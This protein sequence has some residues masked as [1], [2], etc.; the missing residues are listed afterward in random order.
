MIRPIYELKCRRLDAEGNTKE[1]IWRVT[2]LWFW[3]NPI[4][5]V[6]KKMEEMGSRIVLDSLRK[7]R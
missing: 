6:N 7:V 3:Q 2:M 1:Y 5:W 4:V